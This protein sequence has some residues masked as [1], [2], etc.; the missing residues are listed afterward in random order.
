MEP[1]AVV[2]MAMERPELFVGLSADWWNVIIQ[3]AVCFGVLGT[4]ALTS[5][6]LATMQKSAVGQN[7]LQL[8]N[9]LQSDSVREARTIVNESL[10]QKASAFLSWTTEEK[11]AADRTCASYSV[12][13][14]L[15]FEQ[16]SVPK[17]MFVESWGPSIIRCHMITREYIA[18]LRKP[19]NSGPRYW[20]FFDDLYEAAVLAHPEVATA[21]RQEL[22]RASSPRV[23]P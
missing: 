9:F 15:I 18:D 7:A 14:I 2:G 13:G 23:A 10:K 17:E 8:V 6:Q 1:Q 5:L 22:A 12:A 11:R 16:K 21:F 3:G 19:E 20:K 4:L